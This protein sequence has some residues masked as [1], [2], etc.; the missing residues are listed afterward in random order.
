MDTTFSSYNEKFKFHQTDVQYKD[1]QEMHVMFSI[2]EIKLA[3]PE[4]MEM[5]AKELN[6]IPSK[7]FRYRMICDNQVKVLQQ[8]E[9]EYK[10]WYAD[11]YNTISNEQE[12]KIDK[13]GGVTGFKKIDR[14]ETAKEYIIITRYENDYTEFQQKLNRERYLLSL[15][16]TTVAAIDSFSFKLHSI[17]NYRQLL[18]QNRLDSF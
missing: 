6:E 18:I 12:P 4:N 17:L 5:I 2:D 1:M 7:L 8:L 16:K 15:V 10:R 9:D 13:T 11:K 3:D 14:T